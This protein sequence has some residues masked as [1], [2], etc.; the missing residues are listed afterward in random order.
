MDVRVPMQNL[1]HKSQLVIPG[2]RPKAGLLGFWD[3]CIGERKKLWVR[4]R[5]RGRWHDVVAGDNE[6]MLIPMRGER[7]IPFVLF[8]L[9]AFRFVSG[10]DVIDLHRAGR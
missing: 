2:G 10:R 9:L 6:P 7:L 8:S 1:V 5:F 4:Y 3:P